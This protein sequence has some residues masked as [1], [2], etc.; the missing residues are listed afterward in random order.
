MS[1]N[2][3]RKSPLLTSTNESHSIW[4]KSHGIWCESHP[5][6]RKSHR[7]K[8]T[9]L[10]ADPHTLG[11]AHLGPGC[12]RALRNSIVVNTLL[13]N[14]FHQSVATIW[15]LAT[16]GHSDIWKII[17]LLYHYERTIDRC[18]QQMLVLPLPGGSGVRKSGHLQVG[19]A[20]LRGF[21]RPR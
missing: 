7:M 21:Q 5:I 19:S 4:R 8:I 14:Y 18:S 2:V 12:G 6:W 1:P 3:A 9:K 17:L 15:K 20:T 10:C 16:K 13:F 11:V